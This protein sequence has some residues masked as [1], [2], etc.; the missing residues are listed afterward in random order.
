MNTLSEIVRNWDKEPTIKGRAALI[1]EEIGWT[2]EQNKGRINLGAAALLVASSLLHSHFQTAAVTASVEAQLS[3]RTMPTEIVVRTQGVE[4]R[5][6]VQRGHAQ[7][8]EPGFPE[9]DLALRA[10]G[11]AACLSVDLKVTHGHV[12]LPLTQHFGNSNVVVT[13]FDLPGFKRDAYTCAPDAPAL[14]QP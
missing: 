2:Y 9:A 3:N 11:P 6:T 10:F 5:G 8:A 13:K 7:L 1:R 4:R 14:K 12:L